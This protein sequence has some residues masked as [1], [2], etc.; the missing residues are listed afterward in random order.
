MLVLRQLEVMLED[1]KVEE[2]TSEEGS[3]EDSKRPG[4]FI[5]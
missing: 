4:K 5:F 3:V 2:V 1:T